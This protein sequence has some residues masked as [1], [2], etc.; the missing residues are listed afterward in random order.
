MGYRHSRAGILDAA[1]GITLNDG[2][3]ALTF[4]RVGEA[5][6]ISDRTVVYYFPTKPDLVV[7]VVGV[8]GARLQELLGNA[9]G[10]DPLPVRDLQ[11]RAW[12]LLASAD[13]DPIFAVY[14]EIVGLASARTEPYVALAPLLIDGWVTWLTP[15]IKTAASPRDEAL[16]AVATLDGLLLLRRLC[17]A[18]AAASAAAN[19]GLVD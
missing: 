12:P 7:A 17:G 10:D 8:L 11:R 15:R 5:L 3:G 16:G 4:R 13:A 14:F 1:V 2:L 19:L 6:H 18:T 9:F